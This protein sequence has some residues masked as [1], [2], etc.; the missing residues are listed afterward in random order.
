MTRISM[1]FYRLGSPKVEHL[2]EVSLSQSLLVLSF[3]LHFDTNGLMIGVEA[4]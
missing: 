2:L 3:Y 4:F 1:D